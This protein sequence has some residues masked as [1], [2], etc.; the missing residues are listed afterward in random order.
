MSL[1]NLLCPDT[2]LVLDEFVLSMEL[3]DL[4]LPQ[5]YPIEEYTSMNWICGDDDDDELN[6]KR[7]S[8]HAYMCT[9]ITMGNALGIN[10]ESFHPPTAQQRANLT[11]SQVVN[12]RVSRECFVAFWNQHRI[13]LECHSYITCTGAEP[14]QPS[15]WRHDPKELEYCEVLWA[16]EDGVGWEGRI[17]EEV[18]AM[19][20]F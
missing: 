5:H 9:V 10:L 2:R 4:L 7:N 15:Q 6:W 1:L 14:I 12:E 19:V 13:D 11:N 3:W 17:I 8:Y 18:L 20:Q 16:L